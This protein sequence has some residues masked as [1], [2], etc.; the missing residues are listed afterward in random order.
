MSGS[1]SADEDFIA[2][3]KYY[4]LQRLQINVSSYMDGGL[5][6]KLAA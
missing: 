3:I 6:P 2:L 4:P 1:S 5:K